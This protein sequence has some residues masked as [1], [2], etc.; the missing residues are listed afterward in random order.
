MMGNKKF[1]IHLF[2]CIYFMFENV[3]RA[4]GRFLWYA[5]FLVVVGRVKF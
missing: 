2:K 5:V 3:D 1:I 4:H